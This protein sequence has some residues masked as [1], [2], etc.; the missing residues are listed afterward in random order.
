MNH[1]PTPYIVKKS[2]AAPEIITVNFKPP[3]LARTLV[4]RIA[5]VLLEGGSE[6]MEEA[7]ANAEFI[8]EACNAYERLKREGAALLE[9][10]GNAFTADCVEDARA[11][12]RKVLTQIKLEG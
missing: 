1:T 6:G 2:H 8:V 11:I 12:L 4:R 10:A 3:P 5:I 9:A 7:I